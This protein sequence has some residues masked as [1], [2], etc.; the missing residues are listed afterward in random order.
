MNSEEYYN[1]VHGGWLGRV[2]GSQFGAPIEF[3]PY[4]SITKKYCANGTKDMTGYIKPINTDA[5]N[6]D[7]IYEIVAMLIMEERGIDITSKD[8]AEG[9]AKYLYKMQFT[10]E[11][12]A[13]RNIL[14]GLVPPESGTYKNMWYDAIGGQMKADIFG[15]IAPNCPEIAAHYARIDGEVAHSGI[16]I[17]GE[18][19]V[20]GIISNAFSQTADKMDMK[21]LIHDSLKLISPESIYYQFIEKTEEIYEKNKLWRDSRTEMMEEWFKIRKELKKTAS[22]HRRFK[23]LGFAHFLNVLPNAGIIV[24][25]LLY[26]ENDEKDPFGRP[27][28][29]SGMMGLDTDCNCG[30]IGTIMG[31]IFGA[32]EIPAVWTDPLENKF[33]T[34]VKGHVNWKISELATRISD[35]GKKVIAAKCP[36]KSIS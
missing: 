9:W 2:A 8:I 27:I 6:D 34:F 15:L 4:R 33:N 24:L 1:K 12:V 29:L 17:D 11:R 28:C 21:S 14:N 3:R 7:E 31:T 18:V 5:V 22:F 20:A 32:K 10:A 36:D 26:G 35:L 16:G 25:S 23:S 19:F 30:N 13:K